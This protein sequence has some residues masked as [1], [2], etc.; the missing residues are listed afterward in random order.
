METILPSHHIAF[1]P[2]VTKYDYT[3]LDI[4]E[5]GY[6]SLLS[7]TSDTREDIKLP[8]IPDGLAS[9][10]RQ[11][12]NNGEQVIITLIRSMDYEQIVSFKSEDKN[13]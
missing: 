11:A 4:N 10:I 1:V 7:D 9:E 8:L 3:L 2:I 12:Y 13:S 5:E 6:C